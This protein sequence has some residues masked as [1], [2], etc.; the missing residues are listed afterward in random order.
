MRF[1]EKHST[2][3]VGNILAGVKGL[4]WVALETETIHN[5]SIIMMFDARASG[6]ME[7]SPEVVVFFFKMGRM[8]HNLPLWMRL[9]MGSHDDN[10]ETVF[11]SHDVWWRWAAHPAT[12]LYSEAK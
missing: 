6:Q 9:M 12:R 7:V 4:H 11:I 10:V 1:R 3:G 2:G 5:V 8:L